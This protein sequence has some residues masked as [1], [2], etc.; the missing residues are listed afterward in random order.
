V[1]LTEGRPEPLGATLTPEGVNFAVVSAGAEA[2]DLCLF[3]AMGVET[4]ARLPG[5]SGD[6]RHGFAPGLGAGARYGFRA[7]GPWAPERGDRFNPWKLLL[8]PYARAYD[9][10]F[11]TPNARLLGHDPHRGEAHPNRANSAPVTPRCVVVE[12]LP[13][14]DE[15]RPRRAWAETVIYEAHVRG[16]TRLHP[17]VPEPLRGTYEALGCKA[18]IEHLSRLGVTAVELLPI[19]AWADEPR[20]IKAKL[21]NYWG[22]NTI[23]FFQPEPRL[24]GP[25][26]RAGLREAIRRLHAAGIEAILDVVYN[27]TAEGDHSGPTLSFRG[28]DNALY[29]RLQADRPE[30]YE[31][32]TGTGATLD[33]ANP[34]VIRLILDSLR[35]WV[36][37]MGVDGFRFDLAPA[38][39]RTAEGFDAE[40]P[41]WTALR[42]DPVL[43]AV[44]LIAEPWDVGPEGYRLGAFPHPLA[45]WNDGFRD[46]ARRFWRGDAGGTQAL[47]DRLLGSAA[48]FDRAGRRPWASVNAVATHDGFT[49]ADLTTYER[50]RNHANGEDNRDGHDHNFSDG[51]GAE[52]PSDDP[53]VVACRELRRRN[54]LATVFLSQGTPM[55][56]AGDELANTQRGNNNAYCQDNLTSWIDWASADPALLAFTRRLSAF[57]AAH[58]ALRQPRWL[59]GRPRPGD[60]RPDAT[61]R[62]FDGG[63]VGWA[64]PALERFCLVVR[65][66]A[67]AVEAEDDAIVILVNRGEAAEAALPAAPP[68]LAWSRAIDTAAPEAEPRAE[69]GVV[70]VAADSVVAHGLVSGAPS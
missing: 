35:W 21:S 26:G 12:E 61:W 24:F 1:R 69:A 28:L 68:G 54:L 27:H 23:G 11:H 64:D 47:A 48:T 43:R 30:R 62:A 70:A 20:L 2:V 3:D 7:H 46:D 14:A 4:P 8:D 60:G 34:W 45:E 57:R 44:K 29:Y 50:K 37:R 49:L 25:N 19:Q 36:E 55:L 59:H 13:L 33:A 56:L 17:G 67:E 16:L 51:C 66:S 39:G 52:G 58:P 18:V 10:R 32:H 9:G 31:N 15:P 41:F 40:A 42:Q 38:L 65:G 22:Y 5:R 6:V 53:E 63:P